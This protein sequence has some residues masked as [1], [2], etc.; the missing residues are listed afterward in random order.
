LKQL[1]Y[2]W[3]SFWGILRFS[4]EGNR[5]KSWR[6]EKRITILSDSEQVLE[7]VERVD[8]IQAPPVH[9]DDVWDEEIIEVNNGEYNGLYSASGNALV[10]QKWCSANGIQFP[11]YLSEFVK[12]VQTVP[13]AIHRQQGPVPSHNRPMLPQGKQQ[14][15]RYPPRPFKQHV[16]RDKRCMIDE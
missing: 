1:I 9:V 2:R 12:H 8:S 6:V 14:H 15:T 16:Q 5:V 7:S 13:Q 10:L 11:S 4:P 3:G